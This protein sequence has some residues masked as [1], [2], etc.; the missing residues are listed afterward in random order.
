MQY[1]M[2]VLDLD[3]TL[4]NNKKEI[5]AYTKEILLAYQEAG[6]KVVLASGRPTYGIVPL[7]R[8]LELDRFGSY[9]LSFNGGIITEC[10]TNRIL[11]EKELPLDVP[12]KLWELSRKYST[13]MLTYQDEYIITE[14]P[15]DQYVQ[16]EVI[17]TKMIPKKVDNLKEY[18]DF[19]VTKCMLME[20][21]IYLADVEVKVKEALG[22]E[23]SIYRSEP[24]F[25]E[26]MAQG[27]DKA[28]SLARLLDIL[29]IPVEEMAAFGD[30]FNDKSMIEFAG[31]GV[32]MENG[33]PAVKAAAD[34]IAPSNEDEG[35]AYVVEKILAGERII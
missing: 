21:G 32:A 12:A 27:I 19:P 24:Y 30:G 22:P 16:K 35:V 6:G 31:L 17:C 34:Y 2:I 10:G 9:I 26:V 20:R 18:V 14:T 28:K 33:Q 8:E 25:L 5:T 7:A 29:K 13:S 23:L 3:G 4:T 15:D 11:Y 1:K